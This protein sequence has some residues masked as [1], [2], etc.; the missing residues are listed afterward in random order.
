MAGVD[1]MVNHYD[2]C[3]AL[4]PSGSE[5]LDVGAGKGVFACEMAKRGF[6]VFGIEV[7]LNYI[8]QALK[9]L[10]DNN[11][12]A[13]I[14][15]GNAEILPYKEGMFSFIN[16]SEVT[17]HVNDPMA[18][19]MEIYRVLKTGGKA[20]ISFHNRFGIYDY[21]YHLYFI[22]WIP[23]SWTEFV[24][25]L[26][27][28]Q[29]SDGEAGRQKLTTMH[30]YTFGEVKKLLN[31]IGFSVEDIRINKIKNKFGFLS[32]LFLSIYFIVLRPFYFN[33]FHMLVSKDI[34]V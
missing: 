11:L 30:Y 17:E 27:N 33:T 5:I 19:C 4:I 13:E 29:K 15:Q 9:C 25:K 23:R 31:S 3:A 6:K 20:Y 16:S 14:I 24:L 28:K 10:R 2:Y 18:V 8:E 34:E 26:L 22:N 21:H 7:N 32:L 12:S 1:I